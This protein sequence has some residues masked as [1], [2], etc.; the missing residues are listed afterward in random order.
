MRCGRAQAFGF[1]V[2]ASGDVTIFLRGFPLV[3]SSL[4]AE[5]GVSHV[6]RFSLVVSVSQVNVLFRLS[7]KLRC[8][9]VE[10]LCQLLVLLGG[11]SAGYQVRS[12]IAITVRLPIPFF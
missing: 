9:Q 10:I 4:F 1:L 6:W 3:S 11:T 8:L 5:G 12:E 7:L 2:M